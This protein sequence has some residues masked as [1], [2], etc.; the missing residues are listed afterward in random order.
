MGA[1]EKQIVYQ[2]DKLTLYRFHS[3]AKRL[4]VAPL[5]IV[6]ALIN[7]PYILDITQNCSLIKELLEKGL[8]IYLIDWGYPDA[9]DSALSLNKYISGYLKNCVN[10]VCQQTLKKQINLMGIC[11]G[12]LF[13]LCYSMQ[14][15]PQIKN[16]I[17]VS[18][19]I[20]FHTSDNV[21]GQLVQTIDIDLMV[22]TM[23]NT[24]GNWLV[25]SFMQMKPYY[26]LGKKY[27]NF[28]KKMH[29]EAFV[30]LFM[31]IEKW[32]FDMPDHAGEAFREFIKEFYQKNNLIKGE[33]TLG[34]HKLNLRSITMPV[35]NVI[36]DQ[37]YLVPPSASLCLKERIGTADYS[38]L[39]LSGG[40]IGIYVNNKNRNKLA[41]TISEWMKHRE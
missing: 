25:Q 17:T 10:F 14:Y 15:S 38:E 33:L 19:P 11:Q 37:D 4:E 12:G 6:F 40:H 8:D 29:D 28:I 16:L 18:T 26:L 22:D 3:K 27:L 35:L 23:E 9:Q 20:N 41:N 31:H 36:A 21:L 30:Q 7:R 2:Q 13:S 1:S 34:N 39:I 24:A 32:I 5:L